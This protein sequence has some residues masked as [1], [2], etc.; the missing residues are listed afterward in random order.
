M[1][2]VDKVNG[3]VAADVAA[4]QQRAGAAGRLTHLQRCGDEFM[5]R[6]ALAQRRTHAAAG[7]PGRLT[8]T[9]EEVTGFTKRNTPLLLAYIH[10]YVYTFCMYLLSSKVQQGYLQPRFVFSFNLLYAAV[11]GGG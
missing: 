2:A 6:G 7:F 11:G 8:P 5:T 4:L 1:P 3:L 10:F 9:E